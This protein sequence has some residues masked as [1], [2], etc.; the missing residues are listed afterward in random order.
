MTVQTQMFDYQTRRC[1]WCN[2]TGSV[3][4]S[5]ADVTEWKMGRHAQDVWPDLDSIVR[6]QIISGTH[7][8][9]WEQAFWEGE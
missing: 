1:Y 5:R 9:C 6:E 7:P 8:K 3:W 2:K 4:L